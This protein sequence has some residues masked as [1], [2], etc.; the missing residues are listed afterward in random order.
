[1]LYGKPLFNLICLKAMAVGLCILFFSSCGVVPK[2]YPKNKPFVYEYKINLE[3]NFTNEQRKE[4]VDRL[5]NQLDDSIHVRTVRKLWY[6]G[7]N[8][9]VIVKPPVYDSANADKSV[10]YMQS[11]LKSLG[12]FKDTI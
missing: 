9:P 2:N 12:Y 7:I 8:R 5:E 11:L 3:G 1:M 4:L 6:K 10:I